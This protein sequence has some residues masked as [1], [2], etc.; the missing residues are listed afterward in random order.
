M[1]ALTCSAPGKLILCG[2][3]AVVYSQPAIA[4]P[5]MQLTTTTKIFAHPTAPQGEIFVRAEATQTA[6]K[7]DSL[8]AENPIRKTV[9]LVKGYF[10]LDHFPACEIHISSTLP[11]ASGLGSSASLSVSIIC[12]LTQFI[13]HPLAL[14]Q[15]N[16]LA[17]EAE[18]FHHGNPSGVDNTVIT[19]QRPVYFQR[20]SAP[21]FIK[22]AVPF[23]FVIASTGISASTSQAVAGVHER[24]QQNQPQYN[25]LFNQIGDLTRQVRRYLASGDAALVGTH[26]SQDHAL[27]TEMGV[28]C[29][30]LDRLVTAAQQAGA[31]GAKLSGGGQGGYML[32]LVTPET[33]ARVAA[34]LRQNG[35][36]TT[37][38]ISLPASQGG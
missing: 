20:G 8:P 30:A 27:L 10:G 3:H 5:V 35:A 32:A 4:M 17:Y 6:A 13:G 34:A 2:E 26:L 7:L 25:A 11:I 16:Q 29:P 36:V 1:P 28:S 19:Y 23:Y 22:V 14:E 37:L 24:W 12:A 18:K 33:S 9:E 21:V 15:I 38:P 31:L